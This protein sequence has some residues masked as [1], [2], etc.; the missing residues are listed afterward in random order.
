MTSALFKV[1]GA[2]ND[3]LLGIGEW[4]ERLSDDGALVTRLCHRRRGIGA[5]GALAIMATGPDR[6]RLAYRN[7]DGSLARFCGN[8]T[9]CAARAGVEL[10]GLGRRL[11]V[12]TGWGPIPAEVDG[13]TVRL[14]LPANVAAQREV[15]ISVAGRSRPGWWLEVGVPHLVV[16]VEDV[17]GLCLEVEGPPLSRHEIFGADGGNVNFTTKAENGEL[18]LRTY[19]RGVEGETLCCGSGVVAAALVEMAAGG[20]RLM[21]VRARSGDSLVVEAPEG[22]RSGPIFLSGP[23]RVIAR[24]DPVEGLGARG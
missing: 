3:F 23:T 6:L 12:D 2:G 10:L 13:E 17:D 24:I 22:P 21:T 19:E 1:E 15:E 5:D 11:I 18:V 9:R 7:G 8:G 16:P 14:E 20:P 4:A